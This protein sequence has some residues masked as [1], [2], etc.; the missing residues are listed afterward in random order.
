M[1]RERPETDTELVALGRDPFLIAYAMVAPNRVVVT[2]E[3]SRTRQNRHVPEVFNSLGA[4]WC[5]P[6]AF[7]KALG[8]RT[9]WKT[10][11]PSIPAQ[12]EPT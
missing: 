6:L 8:F 11:S 9:A 4:Q 12:A 1:P 5:D 7:N 2:S 3:V 10:K